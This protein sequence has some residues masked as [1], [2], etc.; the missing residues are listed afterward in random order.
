MKAIRYTAFGGTE[1]IELADVEKPAIT[2]PTDVLVRVK[3]TAVNPLDMKIRSGMAQ[4]IYPVQPPFIPGLEAAG[5]VEAVG[6]AVTQVK[7]GD[8]VMASAMGG[9][10]AEYA[11][12]KEAAV[13][14][15][16]ERINF[17]EAASLVVSLGTAWSILVKVGEMKAGQR[18][19]IQGAGGAVGGILVQMAKALGVY[20]IGTASGKGIDA[21]KALGADEV[22]DYKSQ[23]FAQLVSDVDLVADLVGGDVQARSFGCL[24]NGGRLV[25]I[26]MPPSQELAQQ[27]GVSASFVSSDLS[28]QGLQF[29]L[30]LLAK[31]KL[32]PIIAHTFKLEEAAQAQAMV[33]AGGVNGKV[34]LE[35]G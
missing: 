14:P 31:G 9:T 24:K 10:Y 20:V 8:A 13:S 33:S 7:V 30:D 12:F 26:T 17:L 18:L 23:D 32:K 5:I 6:D 3:A 19:L 29:G 21:L 35:V 1:V 27:H 2:N 4:R 28:R 25:S 22:I 15:K 16:P 34:V 11:L